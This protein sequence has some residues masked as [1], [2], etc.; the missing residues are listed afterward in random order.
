M[1]LKSLQKEVQLLK[2]HMFRL[3]GAKKMLKKFRYNRKGTAE[4]IGSVMFIV[5]II[6]FFSNVYLW[7]DQGTKQM[8]TVLSEKIS[9]QVEMR[10]EV[11][12]LDDTILHVTNVGGT[13]TSLSRLWINHP[14]TNGEPQLV[15]LEKI[16]GIDFWVDAGETVTINIVGGSSLEAIWSGI[17]SY[18]SVNVNYAPSGDEVFLI[19]TTLGN[20]A[21]PK[22]S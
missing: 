12:P 4:V 14:T 16:G 3:K 17:T 11:T 6:F 18:K 10:R 2:A 1:L 8:N 20:A 5:I 21:T 7:H 13:G 9:S 15:N 22:T 19:V